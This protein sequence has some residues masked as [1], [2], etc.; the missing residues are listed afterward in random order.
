MSFF[1]K[2]GLCGIFKSARWLLA[3]LFLIVYGCETQHVS[4]T[5][6]TPAQSSSSITRDEAP[7]RAGQP[8]QVGHLNADSSRRNKTVNNAV[9]Y[10][11]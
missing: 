4:E 5:G 11:K 9:R 1:V 10:D 7:S 8:Q 6:N 3:F 2:S